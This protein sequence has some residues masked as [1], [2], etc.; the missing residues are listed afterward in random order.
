MRGARTLLRL[1]STRSWAS[2]A[3]WLSLGSLCALLLAGCN[4]NPWPDGSA[5][6]NTLFTAVLEAS[7]R[8]L[9]PVASYWSNDT[10]YTY[11]IYEPPYGY[12]YLKRPY[13]LVP[14][15]AAAVV[16]PRYLDKDGK[17]LPEDAPGEIVAESIYDVPI[18]PGIL[19]Q[20][21]PAFA[22]DDQGGYRYHHMKPG[23]LGARRSPLQFEHQGTRELVAEDFVYALK[24]QATTRITTP[25]FSTF[26]QYVVGLADYGKLIRAEDAR[27]R[28]GE[29][30]ASLDKPFLDFRRW[31]LAGASAPSKHLLRIRIKGKYPQW[32]YW[33]QMTFLSPVP[34][35]ADAFYA[36][37][38]MAAA[39]LSLDRWPVG[40]GAYMMAEFEQDRRHV[41]VRNP[42]YRG[43]PY[44][45][46][47]APGDREAG[48]LADCG[49]TMPFIDRMVF[50]I[51]R[52]GVPR[53][54]K[55]RQGYYDVEVFERTDTGMPYLVGMQDSEDVK[56]EYTEKGF[57][58]SRGTDVGSYFI[59]FN[60]LDPVIGASSDPQQ[61]AR[62]RRLRQAISIAIDWDEWSRIFP[63]EG[64]QTAMSPLPPG[65][66]GSREGTRQGM[67]PI[68]HVWKDG[69]AVRR[70]IEDAQQLMVEAGY[71]GGRD[72]KT[73]QPLVINY[74]YYSAPTPGNRPK[75]DWMVRQF[76]KLG[77]QLEIRATD[78][79]Q[80]Q[81][82][83]R[84]GTYQVFWLG[85]L[86][87]YPDAE[88]FLFLLQSSAGKTKHDGENTA[89]YENP[90]FDRM[91]EKMKLYDDG[92]QKQA[93]IDELVQI[94]REDAPWSFGFFPWS[95]GAAQRWVYNYHPVI[96]IRDQGRYLRLDPADRAAALAAWNRPVW[97]PLAL[98][99]AA[100][101]LLLWLARRTLR[102]RE[103]T[104]GRGEVLAQEAAR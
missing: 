2:I 85:W 28:A 57:R 72:A 41:L 50:S 86:A 99:A 94:A 30:P 51:E 98:I 80:F 12:H 103:R 43:E 17:P 34:W 78:N 101:L 64:G 69:K 48:L 9:D 93:L 83:V 33:M 42:N 20:P 79:N 10:P 90:A 70:P 59:G 16:K 47:G 35:E 6:T 49:K 38:G 27:L 39:G 45:C 73:G 40:T 13:E 14:K 56:R 95:S 5:S 76:A 55:F 58:L 53:Q 65:I 3:A 8:H 44:P 82:K 36:Q 100:L 87:D 62:N 104:T 67:N 31:P 25:I 92:P 75:L 66:F 68:T 77:I 61:N 84:K 29:D 4:N 74:D 60:M 23:E 1:R 18:K 81:D 32:S 46:E 19:F 97:W 96:M 63:K 88:N 7:P 15:S 71:P 24:R 11:Q 54:N 52:E 89:N 37:P 91:F 22:K 102:V 26:A 21:H